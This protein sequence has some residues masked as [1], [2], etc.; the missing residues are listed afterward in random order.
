[1]ASPARGYLCG[2]KHP[3]YIRS[4]VGTGA[5]SWKSAHNCIWLSS[6]PSR[7]RIRNAPLSKPRDATLVKLEFLRF[8]THKNT[9]AEGLSRSVPSR[10]VA[11]DFRI[12]TAICHS[13][14]RVLPPSFPEL[15]FERRG[16]AA[17]QLINNSPEPNSL[18]GKHTVCY[19]RLLLNEIRL[20]TE[21]VLQLWM[22]A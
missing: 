22:E 1:M 10:V 12:C 7:K 4:A 16:E 6:G 14:A 3:R 11:T 19:L 15:L 13:R 18:N 8:I 5:L 20:P 17:S 2:R 9:P 21:I